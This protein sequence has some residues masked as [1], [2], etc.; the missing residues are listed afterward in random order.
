[1]I[2]KVIFTSLASK[3]LHESF[4]WYEN[5]TEG[6]GKRFVNAVDKSLDIIQLNPAAFQKGKS[7]I[8]K[9]R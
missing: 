9:L 8:T 6:L 2:A 3:E 1:M 5:R 7:T 4:E